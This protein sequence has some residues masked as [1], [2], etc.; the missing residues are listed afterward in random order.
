MPA[1]TQLLAHL[2]DHVPGLSP[3]NRAEAAEAVEEFGRKLVDHGLYEPDP[4]PE[5]TPEETAAAA[6]DAGKDAEIARLRAEL[7]ARDAPE[8]APPE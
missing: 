5:P 2:V 6:A 1:I 3:S 4:E 8:P 7:A